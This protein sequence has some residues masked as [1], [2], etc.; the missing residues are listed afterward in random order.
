MAKYAIR[1]LTPITPSQTQT[2]LGAMATSTSAPKAS[3]TPTPT[4][5][6]PIRTYPGCL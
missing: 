4:E 6:F 1:A 3:H 2:S 5:R